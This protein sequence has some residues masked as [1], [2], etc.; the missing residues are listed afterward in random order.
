MKDWT[1]SEGCGCKVTFIGAS[2]YSVSRMECC[3]QH[4]PRGMM[5]WR[6]EFSG[7]AKRRLNE[8]L[9]TNDTEL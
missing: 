6:D 3:K 7:R 4:N 8:Y 1:Y 5:D 9:L 2:V